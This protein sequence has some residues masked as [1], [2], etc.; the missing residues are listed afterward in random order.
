MTT[1]APEPALE[2]DAEQPSLCFDFSQMPTMDAFIHCDWRIV[3]LI[4]PEGEGKC[5]KLGTPVM[6]ADGSIKPVQDIHIGES[7]MGPDSRPRHVLSLGRGQEEMYEVVPS[8][9]DPFTCNASHLLVLR[10]GPNGQKKNR[11]AKLRIG[12]TVVLSVKDYLTRS[13]EFRK[14]HYLY[15]VGIE[16]THQEVPVEPYWM[17]L[18]LGDGDAHQPA[19]TTMDEE[20]VSYLTEQTALRGA[21]LATYHHPLR[22]PRYL[23]RRGPQGNVF[24][25]A[26]QQYGLL[27]NKHIPLSYKMG[28]REQRL[29]LL[30]GLIDTDGWVNRTGYQLIFKQQGLADD[31]AFLARSLGFASAVKPRTKRITARAFSATY[32]HVNIDGACHEI[33][34]R[35]KRKQV[36]AR[37]HNK[38]VLRTG[39]KA[40]KSVGMGDYYGFTLDG[41]G[42]FLLG[43]FT[44][45]HNTYGSVAA[46]F[47]HVERVL[48]LKDIDPKTGRPFPMQACIVRDTHANI[49]RHMVKSIEKAA[50]G[51]VE[52]HQDHHKM[53]A[54]DIEC[55]L[56]GMDDEASS[57]RLQG[58][59]YDLIWVEEPAPVIHTGNAGM[60]IS[61]YRT[62]QR[63][64][65]G[66]RTPKRLQVSMNPAST[67]HWTHMEFIQRPLPIMK[68]F[69]IKKGENPFLSKEDRDARALAFRDRPDLAKRYD[70]GDFGAV[71]AGIAI[72]PEFSER[73]HVAADANGNPYWL[74]PIRGV[75]GIRLWDGG[76][77][78]SCVILQITPSGH[79]NFLDC[80]VGENMGMRQMI[81]TKLKP[82]LARPRYEN[83]F[84]WR[85]IGDP[86]INTRDQSDS[87]QRAANVIEEE[88]STSK[89][90]VRFESGVSDW[91]TRREGLKEM[92]SRNIDGKPVVQI[93]H[94]PT[95][96]Q[97]CNWLLML[98]SGGYQYPVN[99]VGQVNRD[100]PLKNLYS[101]PGDAISHGIPILLFP[102][103]PAP[104]PNRGVQK[105][106]R[107][108]AAGYAVRDITN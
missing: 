38:D 75:E 54:P 56:L 45:T 19:F 65:R 68:V 29:H 64:I 31:V 24:Q 50:G 73:I 76:L 84:R 34:V 11:K 62:A 3:V 52:F 101:H 40:V 1:I 20:I 10:R 18:W 36:P 61:V 15:R 90:Q 30:A 33:P 53:I 17:G 83:I 57:A 105:Q 92:F 70:E 78:P 25:S 81:K 95:E 97:S 67:D 46:L 42:L 87:D 6:M 98:F 48:P 71:W 41:D 27:Q 82:V 14:T 107:A 8:K 69:R 96:G 23:I 72:T 80:I 85:D 35:L 74:L 86:A 63:R 2:A 37:R 51:Y 21:R 106:I 93:N 99:A 79:I 108:R 60:N 77:N 91:N 39:I 100:G 94:R 32:Y 43:D 55:D 7:V 58:G 47:K 9:G 5:L 88:L 89:F 12:E 28:S 13:N 26:L 66:G 49:K 22:C 102:H 16:T 59:E 44:V 103:T 104:Q 4:G